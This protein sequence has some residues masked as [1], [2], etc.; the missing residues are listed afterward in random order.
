MKK[1]TSVKFQGPIFHSRGS[2]YMG[3][4]ICGP[5]ESWYRSATLEIPAE[6]I[7]ELLGPMHEA[8]R[9][10]PAWATPVDDPCLF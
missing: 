10:L 6:A 8:N 7:D 2:V 9:W 5:D 4:T 3:V 1:E